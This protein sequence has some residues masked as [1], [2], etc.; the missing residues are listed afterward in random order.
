[1]A[2]VR[3]R[4][5]VPWARKTAAEKISKM[6]RSVRKAWRTGNIGGRAHLFAGAVKIDAEVRPWANGRSQCNQGRSVAAMCPRESV[7]DS[8]MVLKWLS[9]NGAVSCDGCER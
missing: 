3:N 8:T 7:M 2:W 6:K 1:M 4:R 9:I 5:E